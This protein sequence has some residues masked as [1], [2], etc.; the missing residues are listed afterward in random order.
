[1]SGYGKFDIRMDEA[2]RYYFIDSNC[3]PVLVSAE[4]D[5]ALA[6]ILNLHGIKFVEVLKRLILSSLR[7]LSDSGGTIE[8]N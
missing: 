4:M 7:T 1:M 8:V 6:V 3:N 5:G 2:G